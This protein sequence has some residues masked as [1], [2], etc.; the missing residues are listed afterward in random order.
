MLSIDSQ[1]PVSQL[2]HDVTTNDVYNMCAVTISSAQDKP[3]V[4]AVYR[5]PWAT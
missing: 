1:F 5:V 2:S 4:I 3:L